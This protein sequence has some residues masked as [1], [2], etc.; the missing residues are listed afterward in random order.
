MRCCFFGHRDIEENIEPL[1]IKTIEQ[2]IEL[3]V[4]DF[5]V[6]NQGRFDNIVYRA[7][8]KIENKDVR[9]SVVLAYLPKADN[10]YKNTIYPEG[11]ENAPLRFAIFYR[12]K[13]MIENSDYVVAYIKRNFGGASKFYE[14]A[15]RKG[16]NVINIACDKY[17][18]G[19]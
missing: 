4:T 19:M 7:F 9:L 12:N 17:L 13:W 6:G 1:L 16:K 11:L 5:Y 14:M 18:K 2:L 15:K 8:E 3:G 10:I